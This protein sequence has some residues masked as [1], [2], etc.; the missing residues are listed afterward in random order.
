[1]Q[2][3]RFWAPA[4]DVVEAPDGSRKEL[5]AWGW[6]DA[7]R[8][9]ASRL[10]R[11]RL[12]RLAARVRAGSDLP[13]YPYASRPLREQVLESIDGGAEAVLT[14]NAY[15]AI[16]LNA[17]RTLFID[18]DLPTPGFADRMRQLWGQPSTSEAA[19]LGRVKATLDGGGG[20]YRLYR[21]AGGF[22]ILGTD[23]RIEPGSPES[24]RL[25]RAQKSFRARLTPKPWRCGL[26]AP[27]GEY[28]FEREEDQAA[29]ARWLD[30][31]ARASESFATCRFVEAIGWGRVHADN[32][33]IVALH[34]ARSRAASGLPLA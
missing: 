3:P 18:V 1:M 4:R 21:T 29:F 31:Y 11:E 13:R 27:P 30:E 15:G 28:P 10:A 26:A 24:E 14:R 34:D 7:S 20:S 25:C 5:T 6:S 22:R 32:A 17:A 9:A 33:A 8:E 2:I 12:E 19:A 16:V 23:S